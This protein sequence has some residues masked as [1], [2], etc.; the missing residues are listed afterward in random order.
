MNSKQLSEFLDNHGFNV[1][2][3]NE[4]E[5]EL[6]TWTQSGVNMIITL[7]PFTVQE[8]VDYVENFDTD[9]EFYLHIEDP[10]YKKTFT[11]KQAIDDFI[12]FKERLEGLV[13]KL[14]DLDQ[15]IID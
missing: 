14:N 10:R 7:S 11:V 4:D 8:F 5:V 6:E 3:I 13:S 1:T 2:L 9:E 12:C 15:A